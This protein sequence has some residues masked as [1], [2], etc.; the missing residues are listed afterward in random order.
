MLQPGFID[1]PHG[2]IY[3]SLFLDASDNPGSHWV[4]HL[5]A[6]AEEMNRCRAM[7]ARQARELA[8]RGFVVLV[9]DPS[10]TGDSEGD[11][12]AATWNAWRADAEAVIAWAREQGADKFTFWG[13]RLGCLMAQ[14]LAT[15]HAHRT[16]SVLLWQ[17]VHKGATATTQFLRLEVASAM[18]SGGQVTVSSLR[19]RSTGGETLEVAGYHLSPTLL[20]EVDALDSSSWAPAANIGV[21]CFEV[22][23]E[24]EKPLTVPTQ[25]AVEAW[26]QS[27]EQVFA[28]TV[29]GEP[30]WST[31]ELAS[32]EALL[33]ST[34][35]ALEQLITTTP[36]G[37]RVEALFGSGDRELAETFASGGAELLGVFHQGNEQVRTG[38]VIVVGGP[39]YR[40]GSHRQ[41]LS[42][43]R[44]LAGQGFPVYRFD[45]SGMGDSSGDY[46]GFTDVGHDIGAAID[47]LQ[48]HRPDLERVVL[49]G[50]CDAATAAADYAP[51]DPRVAGLVM[52]NP[53]VRSEA[54]EAKA[55]IRHYYL[56]RL[57][58]RDFWRKVA[59]GRFAL[60]DSLLS[61]L[62]N[63][64]TSAQAEEPSADNLAG[65]MQRNLEKFTGHVLTILS[66]EDLTAAE[67]EEH[68]RP[69]GLLADCMNA[70]TKSLR[71]LPESDHTF[72]RAHWQSAVENWTIEWLASLE[73]PKTASTAGHGP[74]D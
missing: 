36:S 34:T 40:V 25:R 48:G 8:A 51:G 2:R 33:A 54:G 50:L 26:R 3:V 47:Q 29:Q 31:Q 37:S 23:S 39:Q 65:Q 1:G 19:E 27:S 17:P 41:F 60:L 12:G 21:T 59:S 13:L 73:E 64:K 53:W 46:R 72:S 18:M 67:F 24:A 74:S 9:F 68:T 57:F 69:G 71:E 11:F 4:V 32:S 20:A 70:P 62:G 16:D 38:V 10:G 35:Q 14:Q 66:G 56:K 45:Y 15:E 28:A 55:Y 61:L 52:A 22:V 44:A 49:W 63:V 30:F 6:F 42:L 43:A 7:V 5:P 58:S